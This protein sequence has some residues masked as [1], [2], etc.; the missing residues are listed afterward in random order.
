MARGEIPADGLLLC[1]DDNTRS[2]TDRLL[3]VI[4]ALPM[5]GAAGVLWPPQTAAESQRESIEDEL[6]RAARQWLELHGAKV[7]QVL[8]GTADVPSSLIRNGFT[9]VTALLYLHK[10]LTDPPSGCHSR[11]LQLQTYP[12]SNPVTFLSVLK[13][14]FQD[15]LDC[16]ELNDVRD[17]EEVMAGYKAAPGTQLDRWWLAHEGDRPVGILV[18]ASSSD[19]ATWELLYIGLV[20]SAR[21]RGLGKELTHLLLEQTKTA[22]ASRVVL[23]VDGRNRPA[24]RMYSALGFEGYDRRDVYL[25][26]LSRGDSQQ[27]NRQ[28]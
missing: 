6:I 22:G 28:R 19:G 26:V 16:P 1:R 20:P 27:L 3:G 13:E 15:T 10:S 21:G 24:L 4:A 23:S 7:I 9:H 12:N 17:V 8:L 18:T 5:A 14:S 2:Q 11:R 25:D